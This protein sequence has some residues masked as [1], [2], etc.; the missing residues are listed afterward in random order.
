MAKEFIYVPVQEVSPNSPVLLNNSIPA[1]C[2][3]NSDIYHENETGIVTLAGP[4]RG[5]SCNQYA[6][7]QIVFVA[8]IAVPAT[9]TVGEISLALVQNGEP[10]PAS[11]AITTPTVVD[12]YENVTVTKIV[13][14][15][16]VCG[17]EDISVDNISTIPVNVQ[18][19]NM[20]VAR[21]S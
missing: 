8:N 7:Y 21:I 19:A 12:A 3:G 14:I 18:N 17:C 1:Q 5:G 4:R 2:C 6:D 11:I 9:E 13:R 10:I 20:T 15:P 16:R